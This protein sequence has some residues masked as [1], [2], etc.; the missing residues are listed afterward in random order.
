MKAVFFAGLTRLRGGSTSILSGDKVRGDRRRGRRSLQ[1][2][3]QSPAFYDVVARTNWRGSER[4]LSP[5]RCKSLDWQVWIEG[6]DV[7]G[8]RLSTSHGN[9]LPRRVQNR[10]PGHQ[11][12]QAYHCYG[13]CN[14]DV[15]SH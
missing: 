6:G 2:H 13:D 5:E 14:L 15:S 4:E 3:A 11:S 10:L 8:F 7:L 9:I 1:C 12:E